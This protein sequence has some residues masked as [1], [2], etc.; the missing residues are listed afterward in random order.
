MT[1]PNSVLTL[2]TVLPLVA[3]VVG[4]GVEHHLHVPG[5]GTVIV[6]RGLEGRDPELLIEESVG[7]VAY[8]HAMTSS[9]ADGVAAQV[10]LKNLDELLGHLGDLL[11]ELQHQQ[12]L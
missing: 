2:R 12:G 5:V 1:Q 6:R 10:G 7:T 3:Q 8:Q 4:R 11:I 9:A